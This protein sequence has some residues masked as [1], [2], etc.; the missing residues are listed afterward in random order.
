MEDRLKNAQ[1]IC[2]LGKLLDDQDIHVVCAILSLFPETREWNRKHLKR[3]FEVFID[4]PMQ[5]L[6]SRDSKGIYSRFQKGETRDVAGMDIVFPRPD[7]AD[8]IIQNS[9]SR[10]ELLEYAREIAQRVVGQD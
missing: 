10:E 8:L 9:R 4:T 1:R 7:N 6:V 3:Y 5:D 2:Q